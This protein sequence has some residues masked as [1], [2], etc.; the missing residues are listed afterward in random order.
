VKEIESIAVPAVKSVFMFRKRQPQRLSLSALLL[1]LFCLLGL[2]ACSASAGI[3][4]GGN[5]QATG[6]ARI[7]TLAVLA[8][9]PTTIYASEEQ[10]NIFVSTDSGQHWSEHSAGLPLPDPVHAL[11]SSLNGQR[12]YAATDKGLFESSSTVTTWIA[13]SG[14]PTDSYTALDFSVRSADTL[15]VGTAQHG[16]LVSSDNGRSWRAAGTGLPDAEP[17]NDLVVDADAGHI[18]SVLPSGVYRLDAQNS[19][20]Q[21]MNTGLPTGLVLN[22]IL[23][24]SLANGPANLVYLG[25]N[26]GF[27]FSDDAGVHWK[28][29]KDP[30]SGTSVHKIL[31]D[32]RNS[33]AKTLYLATDAGA[34]QSI[35]GGQQWG[36]LAKGLPANQ[37]VKSLV[38]G[39][40]NYG[41]L[42]AAAGVVYQYPGTSGGIAP[43]KIV[44]FVLFI[45]FFY[46]LMRIGQRGRR[47]RYLSPPVSPS[48]KQE[49]A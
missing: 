41:E 16:V 11:E 40:D 4:S 42:Y 49:E 20:W 18:W 27:F 13:V 10:G 15:Y 9:T 46:L 14:L 25:S 37:P 33:D 23:P 21:R 3:L 45:F 22:T 44:P 48:Q 31:I 5:W 43:N 29:G 28:R 19:A 1:F 24:A 17:V 34:L 32:I 12:L 36:L 6:L 2:S 26:Q 47:R 35:D 8:G 30:L 7:Q 39:S 38:L